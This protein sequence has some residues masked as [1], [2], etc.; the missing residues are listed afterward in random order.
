MND[1]IKMTWRNEYSNVQVVM[2]RQVFTGKIMVKRW[3]VADWGSNK[4][5]NIQ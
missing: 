5:G 3:S 2:Q 4:P 1:K